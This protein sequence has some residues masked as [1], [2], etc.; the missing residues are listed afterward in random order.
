MTAPAHAAIILAAGESRRLGQP[1]Q[2][3][4]VDGEPLVRRSARAALET[5]PAQALIVVGAHA[6]AVW[7]AVCDLALVRV[8]CSE[9]ATGL[10]ASLRAG[11]DALDDR[12]DA[13]LFVLCD[14]PALEPSHL[15]TLVGRWRSDTRRAVASAYADTLGVPAILPLSWLAGL[16]ALTG[17]RGARELLRARS[18]EVDAVP[19]AVLTRDVDVPADLGEPRAPRRREPR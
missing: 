11:V 2:L 13:A 15:K 10:S 17:D 7:N 6:D 14:Q 8:D 12:I 1:K 3:V 9:W 18:A 4:L 19:A 5:D 16:D